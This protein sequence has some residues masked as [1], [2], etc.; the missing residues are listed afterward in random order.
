M[1]TI[2]MRMGTQLQFV[3]PAQADIHVFIVL[4]EDVD[5]RDIGKRSDAVLGT[6]MPGH[7]GASVRA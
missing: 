4:G 3:M 7:D 1:L 5:G 2:A 6:A